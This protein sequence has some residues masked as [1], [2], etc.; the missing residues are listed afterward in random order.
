MAGGPDDEASVRTSGLVDDSPSPSPGY[1]KAA[2]GGPAAGRSAAR[3][4]VVLADY[5]ASREDDR[6]FQTLQV[7]LVG[8]ALTAISLLAVLIATNCRLGVVSSG[9]VNA[10]DFIIASAPVIPLALLA[11]LQV[12]SSA[13]TVRSFYLRA[14]EREIRSLASATVLS[15]A[16]S[17][18]V[19]G[20]TELMV[21]LNS[22]TKGRSGTRLLVSILLA[23]ALVVFGGI[24]VVSAT[25]VT[26]PWKLIMAPLYGGGT[27][28]ILTEVYRGTLGGRQL[29]ADM[30]AAALGRL[31]QPLAPL[32]S[33]HHG[34]RTLTG[35]V[36]LPRPEDVIKAVFFP[37]G[38]VL[39][40]L[41]TMWHGL[42]TRP[43]DR[44][45]RPGPVALPGVPHLPGQV[46][47]E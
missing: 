35:Y 28:I 21:A 15:T 32:P 13:A 31:E 45:P 18:P 7:T 27:I 6:N 17:V 24:A 1:R 12:I 42:A 30:S 22:T 3:L 11:Y 41:V 47:V 37:V 8:L 23:S 16:A 46:S 40:A 39:G 33:P 4:D 14:L 38:F 2:P 36:L 20:T 26:A 10:P 25:L 43:R 5:G 19:V 34:T 44:Y 9:C 29:F